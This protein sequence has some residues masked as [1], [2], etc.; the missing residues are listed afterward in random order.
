[1]PYTQAVIMEI[2]RKSSIAGLIAAHQARRPAKWEG[3]DIQKGDWLIQNIYS[4]HHS[5]ESWGDP[6]NFRPERFLTADETAI[7]KPL[8]EAY[9]PF[10]VGRRSCPGELFAKNILFLFITTL[11]QNFTFSPDSKAQ[12][13]VS[14]EPRW[15][16]TL[17]PTKFYPLEVSKRE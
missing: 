12:E 1:M 14:L 2:L 17:I 5:K 6:E 16:A 15:A 7:Q 4:V 8:P 11:F 13:K 9:I 3:L 10:S